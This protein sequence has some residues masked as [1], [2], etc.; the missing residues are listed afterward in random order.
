MNR[1][2]TLFAFA[3]SLGDL[4]ASGLLIF[5][6]SEAAEA[7]CR[8]PSLVNSELSAAAPKPQPVSQRNSRRVRRQKLH[9]AELGFMCSSAI[10]QLGATRAPTCRASKWKLCFSINVHVL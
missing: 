8:N 10:L 5:G 1:K 9:P 2:M 3:G 4:D 7:R 6:A